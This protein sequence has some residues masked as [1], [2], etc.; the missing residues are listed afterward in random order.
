MTRKNCTKPRECIY[1]R[2]VHFLNVLDVMNVIAHVDVS[3][4]LPW[5]RQTAGRGA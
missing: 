1:M 5:C 2:E 3:I 4:P